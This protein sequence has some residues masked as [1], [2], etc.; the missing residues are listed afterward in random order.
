MT[1][2]NNSSN[3][4]SG[5]AVTTTAA[6]TAVATDAQTYV[7]EEPDDNFEEFED[8]DANNVT[9]ADDC[10]NWEESWDATG[11]DDEDQE[12]DFLQR[13][14]NE[15]EAFAKEAQQQDASK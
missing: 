1:S 6:T 15:M 3:M 12:D 7:I 2:K 10:N 9:I 13:L 8:I 11:W 14:N 5:G 4:S